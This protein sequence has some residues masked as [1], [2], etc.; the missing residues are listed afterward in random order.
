MAAF[1]VNKKIEIN[2]ADI[3]PLFFLSLF[4]SPARL[5]QLQGWIKNMSNIQ[6]FENTFNASRPLMKSCLVM[7]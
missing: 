4:L 6:L 5:H 1:L 2:A 3:D 7:A